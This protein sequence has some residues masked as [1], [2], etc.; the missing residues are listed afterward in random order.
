MRHSEKSKEEWFDLGRKYHENEE[1]QKAVAAYRHV[2]KLDRYNVHAWHN[3]GLALRFLGKLDDA[4]KVFNTAE[5]LDP[6]NGEINIQQGLILIGQEKNE[7]AVKK[8][9]NAFRSGLGSDNQMVAHI[10]MGIPYLNLDKP[11]D[12]I[13]NFDAALRIDNENL[14]ALTMKAGALLTQGDFTLAKNVIDEALRIDPEDEEALR[15]LEMVKSS[16]AST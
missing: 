12:A 16:L 4:L 8:F 5:S 2:V 11:D 14:P 15:I 1:Y 3:L 13:S 10:G 6:G 9:E 7:Q